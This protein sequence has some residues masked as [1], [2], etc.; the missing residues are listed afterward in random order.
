M[1]QQKSLRGGFFLADATISVLEQGFT[2][3]G[4]QSMVDGDRFFI[5]TSNLNICVISNREL[6]LMLENYFTRN[7]LELIATSSSR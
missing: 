7:G 1:Q 2:K 3:S 5:F 6:M 4:L